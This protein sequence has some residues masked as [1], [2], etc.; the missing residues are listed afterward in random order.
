VSEPNDTRVSRATA[1]YP[2]AEITPEEFEEFV[3]ELLNAAAPTVDRL[4]VSLH[5]TVTGVD[6]T[7]DFDATVR[8]E[9]AGMAFLVLPELRGS[10]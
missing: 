4:T 5:E 8:F 9:L 1:H 2:P 6:G 10:W 3:K 7:Y